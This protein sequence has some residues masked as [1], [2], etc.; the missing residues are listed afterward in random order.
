MGAHG[1]ILFVDDDLYCARVFID[2]LLDRG[3]DIETASAPDEALDKLT[4][5][6]FDLVIL[7]IMMSPGGHFGHI[8]SHGGFITGQLLA[9]NIQD[10]RPDIK[11][12]GFS[13]CRDAGIQEWFENQDGMAFL[14]KQEAYLLVLG[15]VVERLLSCGTSPQKNRQNRIIDSLELKPRFFGVGIDLKKAWK[16]IKN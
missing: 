12:L 13:L 1:K 2:E 4:H 9:R 14:S 15:N 3:F 10:I 16:A 5:D 8:E 11:I 7:D 6:D